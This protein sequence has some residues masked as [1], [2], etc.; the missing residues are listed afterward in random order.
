MPLSERIYNC[1]NCGA[2]I[3]RDYN[4]SINILNFRKNTDGT[5]EIYGQGDPSLEESK[6]CQKDLVVLG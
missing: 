4:A 2:V 5:S 3:D 6:N 1:S